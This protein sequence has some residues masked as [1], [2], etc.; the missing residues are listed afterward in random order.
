LG[1]N[2][3]ESLIGGTA[4]V[5]SPHPDDET[6]G[7]GLLLAQMEREGHS[8]SV[9]LATDGNDGWFSV[10]PRPSS[11]RIAEIRHS[12]W[13]RALDVFNV[14][15]ER[16]FELGLADGT[17]EEHEAELSEWISR[18]LRDLSPSKIFVTGPFDLHP[19][20][21]AL[22][23]AAC[24]S[25][26][27]VY[28]SGREPASFCDQNSA[29]DQ[30][31][32]S[33]EIYSYRVYPAGGLWPGGRPAKPAL[34]PTV[35]QFARSVFG[36]VGQRPLILRAAESLPDKEAAI[37]A[38]QSQLRLLNGELRYVWRTEVEIYAK[39]SVLQDPSSSHPD[40]P[41]G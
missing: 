39:I 20:H 7:C 2:A 25:M 12:E 1:R 34:L 32:Q 6:I 22:A 23:R 26:I 14:P 9:A 35:L 36:V 41:L 16:R 21:R 38:Y 31:G 13:H 29:G 19:D 3:T 27:E 17:L 10:T 30:S 15:K 11:H 5:L 8:I 4:L 18:L 28:G 33:P 40:E 24:R 37:A